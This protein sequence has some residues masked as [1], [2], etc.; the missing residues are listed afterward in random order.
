M[1][2]YSG[3]QR[4]L[5]VA[6]HWHLRGLR[7]APLRA[8]DKN[9]DQHYL[10][11]DSMVSRIPPLR[12]IRGRYPVTILLLPLQVVISLLLLPLPLLWQHCPHLSLRHIA[13]LSSPSSEMHWA[14]GMLQMTNRMHAL[15]SP[16]STVKGSG[17][18]HVGVVEI[19]NLSTLDPSPST[20]R[21]PRRLPFYLSAVP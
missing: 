5:L 14:I 4:F 7:R 9:L 16:E 19:W 3:M 17:G 18:Q 10:S 1:I 8:R 13:T 2:E 21:F 15:L 11:I 6:R 12:Q 20:R